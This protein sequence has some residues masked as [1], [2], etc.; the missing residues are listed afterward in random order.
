MITIK[1]VGWLFS[2]KTLNLAWE[3][4]IEF[5]FLH[6]FLHTRLLMVARRSY[7]RYRNDTRFDYTE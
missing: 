7:R 5:W 2:V 1:M 3:A 4:C 6:G